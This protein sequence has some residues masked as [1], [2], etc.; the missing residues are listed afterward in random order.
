MVH[1]FLW[2]N[3]IPFYRYT[4]V[5]FPF[6]T[7]F[8]FLYS[9]CHLLTLCFY[10]CLF[11]VSQNVSSMR[12]GTLLCILL[13]PQCLAYSRHLINICWT[14]VSYFRPLVNTATTQLWYDID[15][16][17]IYPEKQY[18]VGN[19]N[20]NFENCFLVVFSFIYYNEEK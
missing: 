18:W 2:L 16:L 11:A 4:T 5:R 3:R 10:F 15:V 6:L 13:Q 1:S 20:W 14:P 9:I 8:Y 17:I 19:H 7:L 12:A